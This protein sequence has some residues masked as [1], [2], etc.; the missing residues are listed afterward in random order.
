MD[1][2]RLS[3]GAALA[4]VLVLP[5]CGAGEPLTDEPLNG[6]GA[7]QAEAGIGLHGVYVQKPAEGPY[8]PGDNAIVRFTMV[9]NT[10]QADRLTEVTT[11]YAQDVVQHWDRQCDGTAE[12]V[13]A[14]PV[15]AEDDVPNPPAIDRPHPGYH[16]EI[17]EFNQEVH[18]GTVVPLTFTF[19]NAGEIQV[20]ALVQQP[21]RLEEPATQGCQPPPSA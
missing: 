19:Q 15:A 17:I 1:A 5:A 4:A 11:S 6:I 2:K 20:D 8:E 12:K 18:A 21:H 16:L 14:I 3:T 9:N 13:P 7:D 10:E